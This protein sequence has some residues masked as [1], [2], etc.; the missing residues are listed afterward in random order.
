MCSTNTTEE[1]SRQETGLVMQAS[2][3]SHSGTV[4][5]KLND[6]LYPKRG[7][8]STEKHI[9]PR[10]DKNESQLDSAQL[11]TR[12]AASSVAGTPTLPLVLL[13]HPLCVFL[14]FSNHQCNPSWIRLVGMSLEVF[15]HVICI[16]GPRSSW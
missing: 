2:I 11:V 16:V 15:S 4:D 12:I 5:N 14:G 13:Q 1:G 10:S 8:A 9:P 3:V 7:G 6:A